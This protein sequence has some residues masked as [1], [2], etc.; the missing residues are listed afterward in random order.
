MKSPCTLVWALTYEVCF[1]LILWWWWLNDNNILLLVWV[2]RQVVSRACKQ[3][4]KSGLLLPC[5]LSLSRVL[6]CSITFHI[7]TLSNLTSLQSLAGWLK[8]KTKIFHCATAVWSYIYWFCCL[9]A[10]SKWK[11][12]INGQVANPGSPGKMTTSVCVVCLIYVVNYC[13]CSRVTSMEL[14]HYGFHRVCLL[15]SAACF[16]TPD[17]LVK[18]QCEW[19]VKHLRYLLLWLGGRVV[20][21]WTFDQQ[22][23]GSNPGLPAIEFIPGQ[24]VNTHAP[25]SPRS[26]IWY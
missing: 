2:G 8:R 16:Y 4:A 13:V 11:R 19:F 24:V 22:V 12:R 23:A 17:T 5:T 7:V 21:C 9:P 18:Q 10:L 20:R 15:S 26:I 25:L 3:F 6:N 14:V 1:L